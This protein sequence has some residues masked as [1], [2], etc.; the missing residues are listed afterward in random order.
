MYA[1]PIVTT[2][3]TISVRITHDIEMLAQFVDRFACRADLHALMAAGGAA[4]ARDRHCGW[5]CLA[6][7]ARRHQPMRTA[8][9]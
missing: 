1:S 7:L 9:R 4:V 6:A 8:A 2:A 5:F 3:Q